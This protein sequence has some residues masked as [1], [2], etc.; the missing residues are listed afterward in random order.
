MESENIKRFITCAV[1]VGACNFHCHYCYLRCHH[2]GGIADFVLPPAELARRLSRERLGGA[3]YFNLCGDGE[4]ML[5]P[6]LIPLVGRLTQEGHFCD[7]I[8]NGTVTERFDELIASLSEV[9]RERLLIKFSFHWDELNRTGLLDA[10][11]ENVSRCRGSGMSCSVE[12]TP[13]DNLIPRIGEIKAYALERFG[14][15]PH[16]TVARDEGKP[17][18]PLLTALEREQYGKIWGQ[19]DS[20]MFRFKLQYFGKPCKD[21]CYAG[22]WSVILD[23]GT[24]EYRQCYAGQR[25]GNIRD[26]RPLRFRPIGR[27]RSPHCHNC[28]AFLTLGTIPTLQTPSYT[29]MRDRVTV[30]GE[31]WL[32][33]AGRAFFSTRLMERNT[34]LGPGMR[35]L[36]CVRGVPRYMYHSLRRTVKKG[37][38]H[39]NVGEG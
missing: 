14:A 13:E 28:H 3:C 35:F 18:Y 39:K 31:H 26:N 29:Q 37:L 6:Q 17:D 7:I 25:L 24:G 1:P 9:Q 32:N 27:C 34:L 12:V 5:H 20:E 30:N 15:L 4:T 16:I 19:F 38:L 10:F 2:R 21:F 33:P 11:A 22:D 23:L 36:I 8:T